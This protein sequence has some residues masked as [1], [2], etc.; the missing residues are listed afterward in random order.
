M[1][2]H[3]YRAPA[4]VEH[5]AGGGAPEERPIHALLALLGA[6]RVAVALVLDEPFGAESTVAAAFALA[7]VVGLVWSRPR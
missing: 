2:L 3:P 4:P 5:A 6:A 1:L 7:G